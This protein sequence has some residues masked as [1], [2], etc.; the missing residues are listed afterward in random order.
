MRANYGVICTIFRAVL[1]STG[2]ILRLRVMAA[3][4]PLRSD[5]G[6]CATIRWANWPVGFIRGLL[7]GAVAHALAALA[8]AG[9]QAAFSMSMRL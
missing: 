9:F 4:F 6:F 3:F 5:C 2:W 8:M 1:L 7:A